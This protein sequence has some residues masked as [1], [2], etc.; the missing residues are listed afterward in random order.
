MNHLQ[1]S[2]LSYRLIGRRADSWLAIVLLALFFWSSGMHAGELVAL[3]TRPLAPDF[4]LNDLGGKSYS[5]SKLRGSVVVVNFWAS[6]CAPC[7]SEMPSFEGLYKRIDSPDFRILAINL[8][9][10]REVVSRFYFSLGE[11]LTF[12]VLLDPLMT[13]SQYWPMR[14]LPMTFIVDKSGR[15]THVSRGA[16]HWDTAEVAELIASLQRDPEVNGESE[17]NALNDGSSSL[18][19]DQRAVTAL[20]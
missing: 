6:W 4:E 19:I 16:R 1:S 7:R 8:G 11:P 13:A 10:D 2:K 20:R 3:N 18:T 15:V 14:G 12:T 5:L 9:E 17:Q